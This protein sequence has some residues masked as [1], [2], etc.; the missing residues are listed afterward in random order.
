MTKKNVVAVPSTEDVLL[1]LKKSREHIETKWIRGG[2]FTYLDDDEKQ[3]QDSV[4][5]GKQVIGVCAAGSVLYA[6]DYTDEQWTNQA[7]V[8]PVIEALFEALPKNSIAVR[9]YNNVAEAYSGDPSDDFMYQERLGAIIEY[10]DKH[11][12]RKADVLAVFDR[13][14]DNMTASQTLDIQEL[15]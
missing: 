15:P 14:I 10:N 2:W 11:G 1:T 7:N 6:L 9:A 5:T 12:R 3:V 4:P 8:K 13:A